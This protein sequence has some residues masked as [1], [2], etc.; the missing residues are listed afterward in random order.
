MSKDT[1]NGIG[2]FTSRSGLRY[3]GHFF[4]YNQTF[5]L[6]G[7]LANKTGSAAIAFEGTAET[8]EDAQKQIEEAIK[9]DLLK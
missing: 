2:I 7:P 3:A 8:K 9:N 1:D 6:M 5:A 4:Q